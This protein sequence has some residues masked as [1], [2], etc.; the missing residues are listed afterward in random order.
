MAT[1]FDRTI[2]VDDDVAALE[3]LWSVGSEHR[4]ERRA[5]DHDR[6]RV[7]LL[8][9]RPVVDDRHG[10]RVAGDSVP[11]TGTGPRAG[12]AAR[13]ERQHRR[14]VEAVLAVLDAHLELA[15]ET[16]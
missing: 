5:L 14:A 2:L 15:L 6:D 7:A 16:G 4:Q 8:A 1:P 12:V 11:A 3:W 10:E 9:A 13:I